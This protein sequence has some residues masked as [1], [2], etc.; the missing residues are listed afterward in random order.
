MKESVDEYLKKA[1]E[2]LSEWKE[3]FGDDFPI[4]LNHF[5]V[6]RLLRAEDEIEYLRSRIFHLGLQ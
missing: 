1:E 6:A 3:T 5:L 4:F 2:D